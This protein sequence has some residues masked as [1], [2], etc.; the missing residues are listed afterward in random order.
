M[1]SF[2]E[3]CEYRNPKK[4]KVSYDINITTQWPKIFNPANDQN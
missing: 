1:N 3:L 4:L 2:N